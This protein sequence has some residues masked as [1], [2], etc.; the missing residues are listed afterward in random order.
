MLGQVE[1]APGTRR[2]RYAVRRF[3]QKPSL[4][5]VAAAVVIAF[6]VLEILSLH[7]G[8]RDYDEGVYW[9]SLRALAR[10]EPLF[11]SVFA[12]EPPAFFF[13]LLPFYVVGHSIV[14]IRFG[15]LVFGL[16]GLAAAY[17][18]GRWLAG[19]LAGLVAMTMV[20]T[21]PF[22]LD[23]ATVLQSDGPAIALAFA[24]LALTL[25]AVRS[26]G[27]R[28]L[29]LA[30]MSGFVLAIA[31]GTKLS[32]VLV[33][34]PVLIL[35]IGSR[36][37]GSFMALV[38]GGAVGA[39]LVLI[40]VVGAWPAAYQQLVHSHLGAG[41]VVHRPLGA[42]LPYLF[43]PREI[44]LEGLAAASA[45]LALARR[46]WR[47]LAPLAWAAATG[48]AILVYQ[49]LF[50]HHLVQLVPPLALL[51]GVGL[52]IFKASVLLSLSLRS[53]RWSRWP[54]TACQPAFGT[55]RASSTVGPTK[56]S[57]RLS[58]A[59]PATPTTLSSAITSSPWPWPTGISR[60]RSSTHLAR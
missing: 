17:L 55:L 7:A 52:V 50:L 16:V 20:A 6:L 10:G 27:R 40:P 49:P 53:G 48:G 25:G 8:F 36:R 44:P 46:D 35:M 41:R 58:C 1:A 57:S 31:V 19:N 60:R 11:S 21:A 26:P 32:A 13:S 39:A 34:V 37:V 38:I 9:Q 51:V 23:Q 3:L 18:A 2:V 15:V 47:V 5:L 30:T 14:A 4:V 43:I 42:N 56:R 29:L 22:Y 12:S 33:A 59:R 28:G 45:V 24:G 54:A